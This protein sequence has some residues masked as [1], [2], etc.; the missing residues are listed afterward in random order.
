MP[1]PESLRSTARSLRSPRGYA[2]ALVATLALGTA[3]GGPVLSLARG[4]LGHPRPAPPPPTFDRPGPW[5]EAVRVPETLQ[6]D[7]AD[8]LVGVALGV[9]ILVLAGAA[10]NVATLLLSRA[11]ARRH[12]T[13]VRA[14]V[15]ATPGGLA[16]R[17]LGEGALLGMSGGGAGLLLG[18]GLWTVA[19]GAW[20][21]GADLFAHARPLAGPVAASGGLAAL[22][23][24]SAVLPAVAGARRDLHGALTVGA[25][26]TDGPGDAMLRKALAIIQFGASATLLVGAALLLRGSFPRAEAVD[27]GFDP[28][29]TLTF[30]VELPAAPPAER[31]G[32]QRALLQAA[33]AL[34]GVRA[35]SAATPGAWVGLGPEDGVGTLCDACVWGNLFAPMVTGRARHHAVSPGYF[36][37]L[38]LR[39]LDG[40]ELRPEDARAV[41][42]NRAFAAR[43]L[44]RAAPVGQRVLLKG[45]WM[46]DPYL[47]VGVVDDPRAMALG[48]GGDPPPTLYLPAAANPPRTLALAVRMA[49]AA[50]DG[51]EPAM[52]R[53]LARA[54]PGAR[55]SR[56]MEMRQVLEAERA[57]LRWFAALLAVLAAGAT[58]AAAG[59][60]YG[61]MRFNVARRTR[62]IGV[63]MAI[64]AAERDVLRQVMREGLRITLLG[65]VLGSIGAFT[66]ARLL[67]DAF[68]GVDALDP[69]A[70]L[71]VAVALGMVTLAASWL[72][73][74]RAARVQPNVALRAE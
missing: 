51:R 70:Y 62:E 19:R 39:V 4:R 74:R 41:V 26:A 45:G 44:P 35:A 21:G 42:I 15:G 34:P 49:G 32:M 24:L 12:E 7:A 27:P 58:L 11:A 36:R 60:L 13:A 50:A 6:A 73:A 69:L 59:G 64:G 9:A 23:L 52:R 3:L 43:L 57:P 71:C 47:V 63:R 16:R 31:A 56:G 66:M 20:P 29:D 8:A 1:L 2:P 28:R 48:A 14:V 40:R 38:G 67:Q 55:V 61:T 22:V 37:A 65:A 18:A 72:P 30:R 53:A 54:A 46:A 25:R 68:Y 33:A 5:T 10:V 17:A